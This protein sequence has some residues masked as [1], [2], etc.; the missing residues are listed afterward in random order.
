M[1]LPLGD[2]SC[3]G[4][5]MSGWP[6]LSEL[7]IAPE[8]TTPV[9]L[10]GAPLAAGSVTAGSCDLAPA[11]LRQT[12]RRIGRY[13]VETGREIAT[14]VADRGDVEIAGQSIEQATGPIRDAV[15]FSASLHD[16]TLLVGGNNAVTRPGVLGLGLPLEKVGLITLDAHFDMRD[17]NEG[18][19]NGNPVRALI[20]DGLPG[21]NIAQ[22]GLA[23]FAN[24]KKMHDDAVASGNLVITIGEVALNGIARAIERALAHVEHCE[25]ILVDCDID[26]IDRSHLPGAPGARPGGMAVSD[27]FKAVRYLASQRKVRVIDLTEWDPPLDPTDLSALTAARWVAECLAGYELR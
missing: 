14:R 20:N 23:S 8:S 12:L 19:T 22:I 9:G 11:L 16:L 6:N 17:T 25:A 1:G 5:G 10:V 3:Y 24:S 18:L 13:D 2:C 7:L 15:E 27:F 26:V 4:K 21:R